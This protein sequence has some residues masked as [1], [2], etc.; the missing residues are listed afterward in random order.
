M[1]EIKSIA[2]Q[3]GVLA[4]TLSGE[5]DFGKAEEFYAAVIEAYRANPADILFDCETL[6]FI[7]STTLGIFVKLFKTVKADGKAMKLIRLQ[8]KIKKLFVICALDKMIEIS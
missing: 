7:D 5:I 3:D 1:E 6:E 8:P 4:V 2:M